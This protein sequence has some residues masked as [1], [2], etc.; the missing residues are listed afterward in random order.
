MRTLAW[1][2]H[3]AWVGVLGTLVDADRSQVS[4]SAS[5]G[6][7]LN[8]GRRLTSVSR[9]VYSAATSRTHKDLKRLDYVST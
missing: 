7:P 4:G 9:D 1:G 8:E 5:P 6:T 3:V 2:G